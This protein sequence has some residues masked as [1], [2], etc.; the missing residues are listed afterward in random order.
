MAEVPVNDLLGRDPDQFRTAEDQRGIGN[1]GNALAPASGRLRAIGTLQGDSAEGDDGILD[2]N[3]REVSGVSRGHL[4]AVEDHRH[5]L[6]KH[7][8]RLI[9]SRRG[10]IATDLDGGFRSK[11]TAGQPSEDR[12]RQGIPL[13]LASRRIHEDHQS[14]RSVAQFVL[15]A[16]GRPLHI[17]NTD[18]QFRHPGVC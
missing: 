11:P 17:R 1:P 6:G 3:R 8:H 18:L 10:R 2:G 9:D 4:S 7:Y 14:Q 16:S 5:R 13:G 15:T 12:S